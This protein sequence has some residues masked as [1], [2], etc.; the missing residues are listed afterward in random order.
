MSFQKEESI[1]LLFQNLLFLY[2]TGFEEL[3]ITRA[4]RSSTRVLE[5]TTITKQPAEV[6]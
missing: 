2:Q 6:L 3:E 1:N 4:G 5:N